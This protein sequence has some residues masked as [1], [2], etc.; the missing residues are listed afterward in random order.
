MD[1]KTK[2]LIGFVIL[3]LLIGLIFGILTIIRFF[4]LQKILNKVNDNVEKSNFFMKTTIFNKGTKQ[5]TETYYR[6]G[7]GKFVSDDGTYIW[8]DGTNAYSIDESQKI[9]VVLNTNEI[10]GVINRESFASLYPGYTGGFLKRIMIAGNLSNK[11]KTEYYDGMKCTVISITEKEY[12][13]TF[14]ITKDLKKLVKAEM[15]FSNGDIYE[16]KYDL[17]FNSTQAMDLKLPD[18]SQY[19]VIDSVTGEE[20]ETNLLNND[21]KLEVQNVIVE[22]LNINTN[23]NPTV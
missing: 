11:F 1:K 10:I 17:I 15:K 13:K 9:V 4:E 8:Y 5:I 7:V 23:S 21:V 2:T 12:V 22:N 6:N 20:I 16:Y 14:W 19:K 3:I 18:I